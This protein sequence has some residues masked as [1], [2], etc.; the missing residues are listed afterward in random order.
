MRKSGTYITAKVGYRCFN[1]ELIEDMVTN[2]Q[3]RWKVLDQKFAQS[4]DQLQSLILE[5]VR[6]EERQMRGMIS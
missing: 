4:S 1:N 2:L 6:K 3:S 5:D